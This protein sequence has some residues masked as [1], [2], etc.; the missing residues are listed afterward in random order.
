[1]KNRHFSNNGVEVSRIGIGAMSF[2][3]FYGAVSRDE[4]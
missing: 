4:V 2:S 3:N 1:M